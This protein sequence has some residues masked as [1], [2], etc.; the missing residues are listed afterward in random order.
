MI[1]DLQLIFQNYGRYLSTGVVD[2]NGI[3]GASKSPEFAQR[4]RIASEE[5]RWRRKAYLNL[6][7]PAYAGNL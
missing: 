5:T 3:A 2:A 4:L 6:R 7:M 1:L